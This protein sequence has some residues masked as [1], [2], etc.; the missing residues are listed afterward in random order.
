MESGSTLEDLFKK[1]IHKYYL[2]FSI[3]EINKEFANNFS[4][5]KL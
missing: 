2:K 3:D 4:Q 5:I 1:S